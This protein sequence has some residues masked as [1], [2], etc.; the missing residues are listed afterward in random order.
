[1][2][3]YNRNNDRINELENKILKVDD[4]FSSIYKYMNKCYLCGRVTY[5]EHPIYNYL[6]T[7]E[8]KE[9]YELLSK[10]EVIEESH[11]LHKL[12]DTKRELDK[13]IIRN[14]IRTDYESGD[15]EISEFSQHMANKL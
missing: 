13:E 1:M 5:D 7:N 4:D 12:R 6:C 2:R 15:Y 8:C 14:Q 3:K 9:L 11:K 10:I